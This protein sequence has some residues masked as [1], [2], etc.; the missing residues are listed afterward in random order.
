MED[1]KF[2]SSVIGACN[3]LRTLMFGLA[4]LAGFS[5]VGATNADEPQWIWSPKQ[6]NINGTA[7][8]GECYFRKKFTLIRPMKAELEIAAGDEYE[9]FING[10][11]AT[12]GQ[13]FG[14]QT[15]IDVSAFMQPG[16]NLI[17]A[18]V[19]HHDGS[20]VGL[21]MK[22]RVQENGESRWRSLLTDENWKT[23]ITPAEAW[24]NSSYNDMGW[25]RA[26]SI[27]PIGEQVV[28][29]TTPTNV[30]RKQLAQT[31]L[32][33]SLSQQG[34][35]QASPVKVGSPVQPS[36]A[37]VQIPK[38]VK[39]QVPVKQASTKVKS[40]LVVELPSAK[41]VS[42]PV[43][44]PAPSKPAENKP[45]E[46]KT[47]RFEIDPE[48]TVTKV[49]SGS[50]TG[51]LVAMEFN[52][53]GKI[54]LSREGGPLLIADPTKQ[55]T[56]PDRVRVYCD[57]VNTCQGIL[58]LN[59]DVYVTGSG[60]QGLGLYRLSDSDRDGM[61]EVKAKLA[62]FAGNL[63]EHGP[64]GLQLGPDGMLYVI[65]GNG[66]QLDSES[67]STSPFRHFYEGDLIPRFEDPGGHAKGVKAPGGTVVRVSL[68]GKKKEIVAGGIRNAYDL[69][70][71][72]QGEMFI[73][74]SDME[75]DIG[76]TWYRPTMV[77]HV[78]AGA[79]LGWR[80]GWAKFPQYFTDQT[81]AVCETGRGSPSG[82]VLYQ[83]LQFPVR[84]QDTMFFADWSEGRI[85]SV[86]AQ[87]DG[88]GYTAKPETFLKGRPL[89]VV[90]LAVGEDGG[91]YFCTG[92]RGTEGGVYRVTW[93]GDVP[94]KILEFESDLAKVIRHPQP[95]SAW[96]RQNIAQLRIAMGANWNVAIE[97]VASE[98]RNTIK[99]RTRALQMM[100]LYGP[101]PSAK[102][103]D[104]LSKDQS[105]EIRAQA[106]RLCGLTKE[107]NTAVLELLV[108]DASPMVRRLAC[109]SYMRL[110]VE[111][112]LSAIL[113][114]LNSL[115]RIE[116]LSARRLIERIPADQW[117]DEVFTTENKR[118]FIQGSVAL[119]TA[120]PNLERAYKVLARS[121]KLMEG[122]VNDYDFVDMLRAME[123]AL[124]RGE[125]EPEKVPG[126]VVRL[127][128]EFPSGSSTINR[129]LVRI[130]AFLNAG[131]LNGRVEK[132]LQ[133]E[134]VS[135]EDKVH[136]G[137]HMQVIGKD[138]T[139]EARI[140]II[141]ALE[142]AQNV[143]GAGGS[144]AQYL[145][146][147]VQD[148]SKSIT[149]EQVN[150]ILQ[151]GHEWPNAVVAAF[152][153]LPTELDQETVQTVIEMDQ[154]IKQA[155]KKDQASNQMRLGVIAV[156]ARSGDQTSMDYLRELWQS[157]EDRRNDIVIG[158]SQQPED[159]NWAYLVSSLP[160]LDDLTGTEVVQKLTKVTRRPR[161]A[162]HFRELISVGYRMHGQDRNA[163]VQLLEH[164]S[165]EKMAVEGN[166]QL[167]LDAWRNWFHQKWPEEDKIA[168]VT[169]T[170]PVGKH[171]VGKLLSTLETMG[172]GNSLMGHA[173]FEKA[174]CATCHQFNGAGQSVGPDLTTLAQRFSTREAIEATIDPSKVIPARYASKK[175]LTVD[176]L[177]F[178]GMAVEQADGSY[179]VLQSDGKR[180]RIAADDIEEI[181]PSET[182]AMPEGLLDS[183]TPSEIN[184]LFAY[185]MQ[186]K[187]A[188]AATDQNVPTVSKTE[189]TTNR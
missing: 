44:N 189:F 176:G 29:E 147:A 65:I 76:T 46:N 115:D 72:H 159:E 114:M 153:K 66:S 133:D 47:S 26:K 124:V 54:L 106:A 168:G 6:T 28:A 51:S 123:L 174:Q 13:S 68:D 145:R 41:A 12:R 48:F 14:S 164:W 135:T 113:P 119:M 38:Q 3:P 50:E 146:Q 144:Y 56:D 85:L 94:D 7:S 112:E 130:L 5:F 122:F 118:L 156:L 23:R 34:L 178:N 32:G 71:N 179:F 126:L 138:L 58:P 185:M 4:I 55:L 88:A 111:P 160:V 150:T 165:G 177:Q 96:A 143:E 17:A 128:N 22:C 108:K 157:E 154:R 172:P 107:G 121:S 116:A 149:T 93:N 110:G 81:P 42:R 59:G 19:R 83:H 35:T 62:S 52:E 167:K 161:D 90:D 127:G 2:R 134:D 141:D 20:Q 57:Q 60:P 148:V 173:T 95:T 91:L 40:K 25:L 70:F 139:P 64:H 39:S 169:R 67:D 63:G 100:V 18:K 99:F 87:P 27:I 1:R 152:Y 16:V 171:S 117:E 158:L 132:Y 69:V 15:K 49:L 101:T 109:E 131:D 77:F 30:V 140:A 136:L 8:H 33:V 125:V 166:W 92:G 188:T 170:K 162:R 45:A 105:S 120:D 37:S 10:R 186:A 137:M 183:L 98:Q 80:S 184:N 180:V 11:M 75:S 129:E 187:Q 151:N 89:N 175:I 9:V 102:L 21:A 163:T 82:A 61:L 36:A 104:S 182:S 181:N 78:P 97:G 86:R 142:K 24:K 155:G 79:E 31:E 74:D 43:A 73:H 84:Y 103:L 53:F